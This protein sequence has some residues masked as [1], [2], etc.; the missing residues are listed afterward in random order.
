MLTISGEVYALAWLSPHPT[1]ASGAWRL[2]KND[3]TTYDIHVDAFGPHCSC[4]AATYRGENTA[5][6]CKHC[7][8][9]RATGVIEG[10]R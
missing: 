2:T 8:A 9:M 10:K 6:V 3:G 7:A 4:P 1:V 5:D